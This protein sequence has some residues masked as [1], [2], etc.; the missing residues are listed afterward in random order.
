MRDVPIEQA[1]YERLQQHASPFEDTPDTV[2]NRALDALELWERNVASDDLPS[3]AEHEIDPQ[4]VPDLTHTKILT[5]S[6][7][8]QPVLRPSWQGVLDQALILAMNELGS[9]GELRQVCRANMVRGSKEDDG[10]HYLSAID[11]SV[12]SMSANGT[13]GALVETVQRLGI[14]VE[15][16]FMWR[17]KEGALHPGENGRLVVPGTLQ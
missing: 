9:F 1:T 13:C 17:L 8:G 11:V 7:A 6:L 5:A 15:I 2:I 4:S 12:Q 14:G 16:T 10:Y 3:D